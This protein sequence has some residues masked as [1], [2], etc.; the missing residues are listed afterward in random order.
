MKNSLSLHKKLLPIFS[1]DILHA[2]LLYTNFSICRESSLKPKDR[3][4]E[5]LLHEFL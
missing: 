4:V 1:T 2:E 3:T 5:A